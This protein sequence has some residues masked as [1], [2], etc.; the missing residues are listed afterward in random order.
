MKS[1]GGLFERICAVANLRAAMERAAQGKAGRPGVQRFLADTDRELSTL[2]QGIRDGSYEP[3][4]YEQFRVMDPKPRR[5]SCAPFRDRVVHHAV[6]GIIGPVIERRFVPDTFACR[7]G[8][9]THRAVLRAQQFARRH[10]YFCKLDIARFFD[11]VDHG[12]L[13]EL[14]RRLF[15]E[16]ALLELLERLVRHPFPGQ[17]PGKGLPIGN[18]TSQWF[19][20]LY[21]DGADHLMRDQRAVPGFIRY[22]D[23]MLLFADTKAALWAH[24]DALTEWLLQERSLSIKRDALVLAP[25]SEGIPFLGTRVYP[26]MVR[27]QHGRYQRMVRHVKRR[28]AEFKAGTIGEITL[29]ACVRAACA[30][31][32]FLGIRPGIVT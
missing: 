8:K 7:E 16:R 3:A 6:C 22:M 13:I 31:A 17:A 30:D 21:L 14:L 27:L 9:G 28:E 26:G 23:D 25:C 10:R 11:S 18:L 1:V 29:V 32:V 12:V 4:G 5:I 15:R 2:A 24:C 20:N 19:A